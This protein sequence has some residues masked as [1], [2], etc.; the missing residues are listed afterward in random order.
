MTTA[1]LPM[2]EAAVAL[3]RER[4]MPMTTANLNRAMNMIGQERSGMQDGVDA[5]PDK[6]DGAVEKSMQPHVGKNTASTGPQNPVA[7]TR[8]ASATPTQTGSTSTGNDE[9][10]Q[11]YNLAEGAARSP[12]MQDKMVSQDE[13][14]PQ[15]GGADQ[16]QSATPTADGT[17][18]AQSDDSSFIDAI[19]GGA[20]AAGMSRMGRGSSGT[21]AMDG[22]VMPPD[23]MTTPQQGG[24]NEAMLEGSLPA[25]RSTTMPGNAASP[26]T[27]VDLPGLEATNMR[28]HPGTNVAPHSDDAV[29]DV[30]NFI[31]R[32]AGHGR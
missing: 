27:A 30:L 22:E 12:G 18:S 21:S 24:M 32:L 25:N 29:R 20:G 26:G 5:A 28:V 15:G 2:N 14:W 19:L 23:R 6:F 17:T 10:A 31:R 11:R 13:T 9:G 4:G 1:Q 8:S 16:T 3:L 7:N